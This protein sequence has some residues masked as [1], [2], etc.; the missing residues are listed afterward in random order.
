[1][2][3][4]GKRMFGWFCLVALLA[5]FGLF[6]QLMLR[7][8]NKQWKERE[9]TKHAPEELPP[10]VWEE[11]PGPSSITLHGGVTLV[12][13]IE[14]VQH[15]KPKRQVP[16]LVNIRTP[17]GVQTVPWDKIKKVYRGAQDGNSAG[18]RCILTFKNGKTME[19]YVLELSELHLQVRL[20][21]T[22]AQVTLKRNEIHKI[23]Y[24]PETTKK[25]KTQ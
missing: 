13:R 3:S 25:K 12:G 10:I 21:L 8:F 15:P 11:G 23:W 5:T 19:G 1:M 24:F 6:T 22:G 2:D 20:I 7:Q 9:L 14:G 16:G 4:A 17:A 18:K